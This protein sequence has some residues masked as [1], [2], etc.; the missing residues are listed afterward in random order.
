MEK[1][2]N[3]LHPRALKNSQHSRFLLSG[4]TQCIIWC[5]VACKGW[6]LWK[7]WK[8]WLPPPASAS[9]DYRLP[10]WSM[11]PDYPC[12]GL[13]KSSWASL[14]VKTYQ[15]MLHEVLW[16]YCSTPLIL[17][18]NHPGQPFLCPSSPYIL[19]TQNRSHQGKY[20]LLSLGVTGGGVGH[21]SGQNMISK[22]L[23]PLRHLWRSPRCCLDCVR[24]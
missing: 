5:R 3:H 2:S 4:S 21:E 9:S 17:L 20:I 6:K 16:M 15:E 8:L 11:P 13:Q 18:A 12:G 7:L 19:P 24:Y 23:T 14:L 1:A 22:M 10:E